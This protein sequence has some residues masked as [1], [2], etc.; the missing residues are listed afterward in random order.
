VLIVEPYPELAAV[1]LARY[2]IGKA[3]CPDAEL[4]APFSNA[5]RQALESSWHRHALGFFV[6]AIP[7][8]RQR[9]YWE[10][11][12][13]NLALLMAQL[14][15]AFDLVFFNIPVHWGMLGKRA[16]H[17]CDRVLLLINNTSEARTEVRRKISGI[18]NVTGGRMDTVTVGVSHRVG[19]RGTVRASLARELGLAETP[20][21]WIEAGPGGVLDT[22]KRFPIR[23]AR[24]LARELAGVRIGL[25][26]GAGAARG[27][28]HLGVLQVLEDQQIPIDMIAGTSIGA[29]VGA[30][31]AS[32]ASALRTKQQ[33]ID[34]FSTK[35]QVRQKIFDYTLPIQGIIRGRKVLRL[36]Q[37]AIG[38]ADFLDLKIPAFV[39]AVDVTTGEE[40]ILERG[41]VSEAVRA[42]ISIPGIFAPAFCQS[43]WMVDGGLLNPV[44]ANVLIRKGAD[45]VIAVCIEHGHLQAAAKKPRPPTLLRVLSQ[46]A[47][48]V[49]VRATENFAE[50]A[51]IVLYPDAGGFAWDDFHR[52]RQL[53]QAGIT[54]CTRQVEAIKEII[55]RRMA[56]A[57]LSSL[58]KNHPSPGVAHG[59]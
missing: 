5:Y 39:V 7:T 33:T 12:E 42:S 9:G 24:A 26:L 35:S 29:L 41:N 51:D 32:T 50:N 34:S 10:E 22:K 58:E 4:F 15:R 28:A 3:P 21:I 6:M 43:R 45:I 38:D 18:Q 56:P 36:V 11:F 57:N 27:W 8:V 54:A 17:L 53:M 47:N 30:I 40:V 44:P 48:I 46:T 20:A 19:H 13:A 25:A 14:R 49:H 55:A 1:C 23:G 31:Y 2:G 16:M 37:H 52:G 59:I